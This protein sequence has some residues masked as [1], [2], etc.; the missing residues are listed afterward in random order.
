MWYVLQVKGGQELSICKQLKEAGYTTLSPREL[1][2]IRTKGAWKQKEYILFPNYVFVETDY[3]AED[4][5]R[6]TQIGGVQKFLG[7][8][9]CPSCLSY[10]EEIWMKILDNDGVPLKPTTVTCN[11]D[12]NVE[13]LK[14]VLLNFKSRIKSFNKR[15]RKAV[16]EI[17]VCNEIKEITLSIDVIED[18]QT[19]KPMEVSG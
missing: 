3:K 2:N 5:Y 10:L 12:G 6:I 9:R 18:N 17:T 1:R 15:Q 11:D 14:G 4:Y 16:F 7:D 19:R 13:L 8:Q